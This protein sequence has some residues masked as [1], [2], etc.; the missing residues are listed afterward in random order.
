MK[1]L[2]LLP[3]LLTPG[4]A[5]A[6]FLATSG[7][8]GAVLHMDPNDDPIANQPTAF[9]VEVKQRANQFDPQNCSCTVTLS[10]GGE[11]VLSQP[12]SANFSFVFPE[13]NVYHLAVM[14]KPLTGTPYAP[15]TL[16]WDVRVDRSNT[17]SPMQHQQPAWFVWTLT[18]GLHLLPIIAA[19]GYV[20]YRTATDKK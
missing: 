14:G 7:D 9:Y 12:F 19:G 8:I 2:I 6:H 11:T 4:R 3:L 10:K 20:V 15:F 5:Y 17:D 13:R 16:Q 1:F 18:H